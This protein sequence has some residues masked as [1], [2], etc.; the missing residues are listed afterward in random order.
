MC[1]YFHPQL[2]HERRLVEPDVRH[3]FRHPQIHDRRH[4]FRSQIAERLFR[5]LAAN[6]HVVADTYEL[7]LKHSGRIEIHRVRHRP[8]LV[9]ADDALGG[10]RNPDR[11]G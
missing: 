9:F 2:L 11:D 7:G 5:G 3:L 10:N 1:T 6:E 8:S 4:A